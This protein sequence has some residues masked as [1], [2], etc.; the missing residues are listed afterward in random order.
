[1]TPGITDSRYSGHITTPEGVRYN[2]SWLNTLKALTSFHYPVSFLLTSPTPT[3]ATPQAIRMRALK[4][5]KARQIVLS[6]AFN[7]EKKKKKK[8]RSFSSALLCNNFIVYAYLA[9]RVLLYNMVCV[10]F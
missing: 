4:M 7:W 5:Q 6:Q 8:Y 2:E 10:S 9:S 1:M 3:L